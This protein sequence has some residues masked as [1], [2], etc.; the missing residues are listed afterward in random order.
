MIIEGIVTTTS[1]DGAVNIAPMGPRIDADFS[2]LLLRPFP[3]AKTCENLLRT[4][5]GVFHVTDDVELIA[6]AAVNGIAVSPRLLPIEGFPGYYLA[7]ACRW[8]AF[9]VRRV[10]ESQPRV[11]LECETVKQGTIR[12]FL[13]FNRA[14]HAVVEAAIL[15]TRIGILPDA[16]IDEDMRRLAV[17]VDKTAGP[18]QR[19]A[20]EFLRDYL[21]RSRAE[22]KG[23]L[24]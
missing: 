13:G 10:D 3:T 9:E 1:T 18:S 4:R 8:Y 11:A 7:N 5:R 24:T 22:G 12:D 15:A 21:T 17:I 16:E 23:G 19:R 20:F 6:R 14:M 2:R